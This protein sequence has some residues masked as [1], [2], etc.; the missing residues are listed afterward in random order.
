MSLQN[1]KLIVIEI[2]GC[3]TDGKIYLDSSGNKSRNYNV[4]DSE[5]IKDIIRK[6]YPVGLICSENVN[7]FKDIFK[8]WNLKCLLRPTAG[9]L[10]IILPLW[11]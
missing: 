7:Q 6:G 5:A 8:K 3:L 4:L 11:V 9:H 10:L 2:D 1:I